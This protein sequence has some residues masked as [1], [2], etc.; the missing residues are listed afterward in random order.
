MSSK[1]T[2]VGP[3]TRNSQVT[4]YEW[5][6]DHCKA[7]TTSTKGWRFATSIPSK[8]N[9]SEK[10][11][12]LCSAKCEMNTKFGISRWK[13]RKKISYTRYNALQVTARLSVSHTIKLK[14]CPYCNGTGKQMVYHPKGR[15]LGPGKVRVCTA[16]SGLNITKNHE[17][18]E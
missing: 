11:W 5:I 16:C 13:G 7:R 8:A 10:P 14:V 12:A 9:G 1:E 18:E 4:K 15:E 6:C 2:G 17:E 3:P